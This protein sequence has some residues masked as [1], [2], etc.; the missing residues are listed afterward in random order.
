MVAQ[1]HNEIEGFFEHGHH[2]AITIYFKWVT[3][4]KLSIASLKDAGKEEKRYEAPI[5]LSNCNPT[6]PIKHQNREKVSEQ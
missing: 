2:T 5:D 4:E 1:Q 6:N 3:G